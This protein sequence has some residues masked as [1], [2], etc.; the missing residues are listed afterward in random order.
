LAALSLF[1]APAGRAAAFAPRPIGH[2]ALISALQKNV[3]YV[4]VLYQENRSFDSYFGTFPGAEGIYTSPAAQT[5]GFTQTI[6]N[7][8]GTFS[9]ISPFKIGPAQYA[10]DTDDVG[11]A[12][13]TLIEKIDV[14]GQ[15]PHMDRFALEEELNHVAAG[16]K[17]SLAAKQYGE[18]AMA[19]EDCDTIPLLWNY[20]NRFTLFDDVFQSHIGPSTLGAL[21]IISTQ[22]GE[23]QYGLHPN[24][25]YT[26][27]GN[28][29]SAV[30]VTNDANPA[31]GPGVGSSGNQ[32]NLT[33]ATL[34]LTLAGKTAT[35]LVTS[36]KTA[37]TD[38][39][40]V[41]DDLLA[42]RGLNEAT[43]PW[44]WFQE[45]Y[46]KEPGE[47]GSD[48]LSRY[49]P[50]H[51]GPQYFGYLANSAERANLHGLGDFY[52]ALAA[53]AIPAQGG[54]F[55]VK[56]GYKNI[57]NQTPADP[58]ASLATKFVG[59]DDHPGYSDAQISEAHVADIVNRIA[60]SK[61]WSQSAIVVTWDDS[62]GDY[63]HVPPPLLEIGPGSGNMPADELANGPRVPLIVISPFSKTNQVIHSYGDQG[64]VV[65][66]VDVLFNLT[67]LGDLPD[68]Q[69][70]RYEALR[71]GH[72]NFDADDTNASDTDDLTD[73]FDPGRL[74]G[75][76]APLPASYA[77]VPNAEVVGLP[78]QTG[79]GC[80]GIGVTPVDELR[81]IADNIP[82]DFNPRPAS[83]P[84]AAGAIRTA[85]ARQRYTDPED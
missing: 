20:A 26:G 78:Q 71:L 45:G 51:N 22:V 41:Q 28:G 73:A 56:G 55:F 3:K 62:E 16:A 9:T 67:P 44:G 29:G 19:H 43:R 36:D 5:P 75:T 31:W 46:D 47:T 80:R 35:G 33:F 14:V 21:A 60:A 11:H 7:V 82:K 49:I 65:K 4:F 10:A 81:G 68:E 83:D 34:P 57:L 38:F 15:T 58:K 30:P 24:E 25:G 52:S 37:A 85:P 27:N 70:G 13:S 32:L 2:S 79:L 1:V 59:D 23:T 84:T 74:A 61:Y 12:H 69:K 48:S 72:A 39:A 8:D 42:I 50:H 64:S 6:E 40:D 76:T 17:P 66:F 53:G 77:E 54:V 63:D 18:L